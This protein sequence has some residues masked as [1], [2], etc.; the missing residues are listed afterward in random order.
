MG[1]FVV[2]KILYYP[3]NLF[4]RIVVFCNECIGGWPTQ[5]IVMLINFTRLYAS[6]GD[7]LAFIVQDIVLF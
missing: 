6:M 1:E 7:C 5:L 4:W 2:P 3:L